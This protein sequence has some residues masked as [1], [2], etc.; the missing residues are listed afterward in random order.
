[1]GL[2]VMQSVGGAPAR[3]VFTIAGVAPFTT[4]NIQVPDDEID[5]LAATGPGTPQFFLSAFTAYKTNGTPSAI[6]LALGAGT[7]Q[8]DGAGGATFTV[9]ATLGTHLDDTIT[10]T[11]YQDLAYD[12]SFDVEVTY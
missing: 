7:I 12:G 1:V 5:L 11:T 10:S 3:P 9:G 8:T 6:T 4:M 2:A